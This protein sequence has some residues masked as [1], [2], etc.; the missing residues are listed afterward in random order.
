MYQDIGNTLVRFIY[1]VEKMRG[2]RF[3][4]RKGMEMVKKSYG[5]RAG[6]CGNPT[7]KRLLTLMEKKRT[8]L[9]VSAD[10]T[11]AEEL[12]NFAEKLGPEIC[13]FKTHI[14]ILEDFTP[15]VTKRLTKIAEK[16]AFLIFEDRKFADIGNTVV[17]QYS[18]GIFHIAD[19]ADITNAHIVPGPGI[20]SG[21]KQ[22]GMPKGRGLLL[23]A[24]MSS[25]GT[26]AHGEYA[27][28][29]VTLALQND[30][31]VIGFIAMRK[32]TDDARFIH[33]T[34]GVQ[35][36]AQKD[37]LGQQYQTPEQV[38]KAG[39]DIIIVGRGI[40]HAK[41]PLKEAALYREEAWKAYEQT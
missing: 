20:I 19:W 7:A 35:R 37:A 15:E 9:C 28:K 4:S 30:D 21:L 22:V 25:A 5:E 29:V 41:D 31:F 27:Q 8:N 38:I 23:L 13:L 34:P 10:F 39:S 24:E 36:G 16:Q 6:L 3:F 18:G 1:M 32:L 33:M 2:V 12:L 26:L 40:T 14:D 11:R 17:S